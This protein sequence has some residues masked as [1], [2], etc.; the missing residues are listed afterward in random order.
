VGYHNQPPAKQTQ[1]DEPFFSIIEAVI[2]ETDT[3]P[4]KHL[5]R[6]LKPQAMLDEVAA[7]LRFIPFVPRTQM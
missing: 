4:C 6:I 3:R 5:F 2:H 1:S 7:V